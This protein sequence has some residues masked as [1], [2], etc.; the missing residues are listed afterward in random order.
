MN[1]TTMGSIGGNFMTNK[2][3]Q[4]NRKEKNGGRTKDCRIYK[5]QV[6]KEAELSL[7]LSVTTLN[8]NKLSESIMLFQ[9]FLL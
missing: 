7:C 8:A 1:C 4:I 3:N 5:K 2:K 9:S 6:A